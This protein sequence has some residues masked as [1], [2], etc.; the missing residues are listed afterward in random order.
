MVT[1]TSDGADTLVVT[2]ITITGAD[3]ADFAIDFSSSVPYANDPASA[4]W[5]LPPGKEEQLTVIFNPQSGGA[6]TAYVSMVSNADPRGRA[7]STLA[8]NALTGI[9]DG[10]GVPGDLALTMN[11]FPNPATSTVS[12]H[13]AGIPLGDVRD[14]RITI[15]DVLGRIVQEINVENDNSGEARVTVPAS[16]LSTGTWFVRAQS[17]MSEATATLLIVRE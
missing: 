3:T 10:A 7:I 8:G 1:I 11:V 4:I 12:V 9:A 13:L 5:T 17:G 15:S 16:H 6:K 2:G 14:V